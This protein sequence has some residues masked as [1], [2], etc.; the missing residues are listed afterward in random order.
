MQNCFRIFYFGIFHPFR[1]FYFAVLLLFRTFC[2]TH[3]HFCI[4]TPPPKSRRRSFAIFHLTFPVYFN[5]IFILCAISLTKG[6]TTVLPHCLYI[7]FIG[8]SGKPKFCGKPCNARH[9]SGVIVLIPKSSLIIGTRL[10]QVPIFAFNVK[11]IPQ[12]LF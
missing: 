5:C 7:L 4:K 9:S 10:Y 3:P 1:I 6:I 2:N 12:L 11:D 8:M